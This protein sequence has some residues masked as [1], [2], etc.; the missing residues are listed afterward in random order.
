MQN[1][2][3][4]TVIPFVTN[5]FFCEI[6]RIY[7]EDGK[8]SD[9]SLLALHAVFGP[10]LERALEMLEKECVTLLTTPNDT[11]QALQVS[12]GKGEL[13][14]LFP[15]INFC[16]C[17]AFAHQVAISQT[18]ITCKHVLAARLSQIMGRT[19]RKE[20]TPEEVARILCASAHADKG[21]TYL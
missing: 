13:Y 9:E 21:A 14:T 20:A 8:I 18:H 16:P 5:D 19:I 1:S 11:R 10:P 7:N 15:Y 3:R 2:V 4:K 6:E 12:G 17:L